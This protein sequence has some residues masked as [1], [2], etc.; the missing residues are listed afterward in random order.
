MKL[1]SWNIQWGRGMESLCTAGR[2]HA[3]SVCRL[4]PGMDKIAPVGLVR[5]IRH[6]VPKAERHV[7]VVVFE[8]GPLPIQFSVG[9]G[10][11]FKGG[12]VSEPAWIRD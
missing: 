8:H 3:F 11:S 12:A 1:L 5:D 9:M 2:M 6:R 4:S 10:L 7:L